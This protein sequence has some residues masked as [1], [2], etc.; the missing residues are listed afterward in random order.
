MSRTVIPLQTQDVSSFAK[1]LR[2]QLMARAAPP[3]HVELLNM[4]ARAVGRR[5]F[6][7][8]RAQ[9]DETAPPLASM[10][11]ETADLAVV[12]RVAR[13]FGPEG[14]L[15]RWPAKRGDQ[16]LA[17]WVLWSKL[18][19]REDATEKQISDQLK[20]LHDFGDHALLR[21]ELIELGL[22]SRTPDCRAYRRI[23]Q[24]PPV[25]AAALISR[26]RTA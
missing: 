26:V 1:A 18:P 14:R 24:A 16:I 12:E 21:R 11:K 22:F 4:L 5:N 20:T 9:M 6:Q 2:A 8:L 23:E 7:D 13:C 15:T 17:L 10:P 3:S 25:T 19:A